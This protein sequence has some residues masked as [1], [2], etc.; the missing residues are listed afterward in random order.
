[1]FQRFSQIKLKHDEK[2]IQCQLRPTYPT[3]LCVW[4]E[5]RGKE[6][7]AHSFT[8]GLDFPEFAAARDHG[9]LRDLPRTSSVTGV[10]DWWNRSMA[11][12]TLE[13]LV[14]RQTP[15]TQPNSTW[16]KKYLEDTEELSGVGEDLI[17]LSSH[18][19]DAGLEGKFLYA[20][21][22]S[23]VPKDLLL[24]SMPRT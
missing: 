4:V 14:T 8:G 20:S 21:S 1:M 13:L 16:Q 9:Q 19:K 6:I 24:H 7:L 22:A 17:I 11:Q 15:Q 12:K 10:L 18:G 2:H 23:A 5:D 3:H